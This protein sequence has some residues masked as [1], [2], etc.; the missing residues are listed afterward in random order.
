MRRLC[1][2]SKHKWRQSLEFAIM[3]SDRR[4]RSRARWEFQ[5]MLTMAVCFG[6]GFNTS[7]APTRAPRSDA[8]LLPSVLWAASSS[9]GCEVSRHSHRMALQSISTYCR[10]SQVMPPGSVNSVV[11]I[12]GKIILARFP[13]ATTSERDQRAL[14]SEWRGVCLCGVAYLC[15]GLATNRS[16]TGPVQILRIRIEVGA[17]RSGSGRPRPNDQNSPGCWPGLAVCWPTLTRFLNQISSELFRWSDLG[18]V[19]PNLA[20]LNCSWNLVSS[21]GQRWCLSVWPQSR[22]NSIYALLSKNP[23][24][25]IILPRQGSNLARIRPTHR[26]E[27]DF[28]K[29]LVEIGQNWPSSAKTKSVLAE[30]GDIFSKQAQLRSNSA[31]LGQTR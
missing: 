9:A 15:A 11:Q 19:G 16:G 18:R 29:D 2:A 8:S 1:G 27:S 13:A 28:G 14:A 7:L 22:P 23:P 3:C 24:G 31:Q 25:P 4:T 26:S 12:G 5:S 21:V 17:I 6:Y 10:K 30:L 20:W